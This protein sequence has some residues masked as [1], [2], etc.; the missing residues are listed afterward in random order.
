[1]KRNAGTHSPIWLALVGAASAVRRSGKRLVHN[2]TDG[3]RATS[4]LW[5]A[6]K[7]MIDLAGGAQWFRLLRQGAAHV[8]VREY[9]AGADNH[10]SS[11]GIGSI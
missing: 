10:R 7:T 8:V 11:S 5:A 6:A 3:A 2:V 9:V 1:M 4:A